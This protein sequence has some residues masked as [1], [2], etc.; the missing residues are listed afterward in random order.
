MGDDVEFAAWEL[1]GHDHREEFRDSGKLPQRSAWL[2]TERM[3]LL[4]EGLANGAMV[5]IGMAGNDPNFGLVQI[6]ENLFLSADLR[7]DGERSSVAA[8][9][10]EF[11]NIQICLAPISNKIAKQLPKT[12][13]R[14]THLLI[15]CE[16]WEYLK[17]ELN[18]FINLG[19][20]VQNSEIQEMATKLFPG[21]FPGN[22]RIGESTIRRHRRKRPD[23]FS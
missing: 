19:K 20:S 2:R 18:D 13:G 3:R 16:T 12:L 14:P 8:M 15:I 1:A 22:H 21:Q 9:D 5:A 23:L 7:I 17:S 11:A 10:R 6:P 4:R